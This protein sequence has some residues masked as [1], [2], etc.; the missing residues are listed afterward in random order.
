M[1]RELELLAM[2]AGVAFSGWW[3]YE[4]VN[5][6]PA[7]STEVAVAATEAPS[8]DGLEKVRI[9][10]LPE[11]KVVGNRAKAARDLKLPDRVVLDK[12]IEILSASRVEGDRNAHDV[13]TTI[14][15]TTGAVEVFDTRRE[16]PWVA[17][18]TRGSVG[19]YYG[20]GTGGETAV[21]VMATQDFLAIKSVT[22]SGIASADQMLGAGAGAAY[23]G[24]TYFTGV[25]ARLDW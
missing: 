7:A 18:A 5:K 14:N 12:N 6:S 9:T 4:W 16:L 11:I 8:I 10:V 24:V 3:L 13:T 23:N 25:G 15:R 20:V 22:L 17:V 19:A 21:R 1:I 2:S